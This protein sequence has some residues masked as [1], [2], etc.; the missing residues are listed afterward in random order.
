MATINF[1]PFTCCFRGVF[2]GVHSRVLSATRTPNSHN[3][4][5]V[6]YSLPKFT[7]EWFTNHSNHILIF[8]PIT[9]IVATKLQ[10]FCSRN[11]SRDLNFF[12]RGSLQIW[13]TVQTTSL[14]TVSAL[15]GAF[16][17]H[18]DYDPDG[19]LQKQ[20][21]SGNGP[22]PEN[23]KNTA[24]QKEIGGKSHF[25]LFFP[26]FWAGP[27]SGPISFP[28]LGRR[29]KTYFLAGRLGR[30]TMRPEMITQRTRK[31]FFCVTDVRAIGKLNPG[32]LFDT[33]YDWAKVPPYN[34]NDPR[35]P[36]VV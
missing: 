17:T 30:N 35:P 33:G 25:G 1:S 29:P 24:P 27:I 15:R 34:G 16:R 12:E 5:Y 7:G 20:N 14:R 11:E 3:H 19:L 13:S 26:I 31:Q 6:K 21:R 36:L 23:R 28:I 8:T 2:F 32:E 4:S 22:R 10:G 9:R 18:Y